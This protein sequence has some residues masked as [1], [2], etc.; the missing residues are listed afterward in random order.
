MI[1]RLFKK[2]FISQL[3]IY[4]IV[5]F[6]LWI[7]G[8]I[9]PHAIQ[10]EGFSSP[11]FLWLGE[12]LNRLPAIFSVIFAFI[13]L[14]LGSLLLNNTL[15]IHKV[16]PRNNF[17]PALIYTS[18]MSLSPELLTIHPV[19]LANLF[20]ILAIRTLM[21]LYN[22]QD[23]FQDIFNAGLMV[24][25]ASI[26]YLPF[27]IFLTLIWISLFIFRTIT[28][29]EI[30]IS[31]TGFIIPLAFEA[32]Y[33]FWN[34]RI[35]EFFDG[36]ILYYGR[37]VPFSFPSGYLDLAFA[38]LITILAFIAF[39][40]I[41]YLTSESII[42]VRKRLIISLYFIVIAMIT[43]I[44]SGNNYVYHFVIAIV[45]LSILVSY[46]F[47]SLR[48]KFWAELFYTMLLIMIIAG[49]ILAFQGA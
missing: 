36:V 33:F 3:V 23:P 37:I 28:M 14:I 44:Y 17:L 40:R 10:T 49:K 26:L 47:V 16:I 24:S 12:G 2:G 31:I 35:S 29:R 48:K 39:F 1:I 30:V 22:K 7:D 13:L 32:M 34:D 18:F 46:Y 41:S 8:F 5:A 15:V 42:S 43:F 27:A 38:S 11:F 19:L 6:L 25:L 4:F 9:F 21:G 20:I 45:P